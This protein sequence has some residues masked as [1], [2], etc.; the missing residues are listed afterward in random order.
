VNAYP[1]LD[2]FVLGHLG[3]AL[4]HPPLNL[5]SAPQRIHHASEFDQ[6]AVPGGLY[7]PPA[8]FG[9][10]GVNQGAPMGLE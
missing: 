1:E 6:H 2:P 5:Y 3:I 10:L 7:D 4:D 8:M 9:D